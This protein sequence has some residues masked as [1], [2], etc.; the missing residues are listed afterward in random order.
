MLVLLEIA[1]KFTFCYDLLLISLAH[2]ISTRKHRYF[3]S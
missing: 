1:D 3:M 2:I